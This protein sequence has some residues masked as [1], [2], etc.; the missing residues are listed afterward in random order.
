[1]ELERYRRLVDQ[2]VGHVIAS[3][4][5]CPERAAIRDSLHE[6]QADY[7]RLHLLADGAPNFLYAELGDRSILFQIDDQSRRPPRLRPKPP[8]LQAI[9]RLADD[10][11]PDGSLLH[12]FVD[13]TLPWQREAATSALIGWLVQRAAPESLEQDLLDY[14]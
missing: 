2:A 14:I 8:K 5:D 13:W 10:F 6:A 7:H 9:L 1:M 4:P 12:V 11:D 3:L